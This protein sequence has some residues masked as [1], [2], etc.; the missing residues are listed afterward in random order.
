MFLGVV[1]FE[2]VDIFIYF[3]C[4]S[5]GYE[6]CFVLNFIFDYMFV[7]RFLEYVLKVV[8]IFKLCY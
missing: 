1:I 3:N 8:V 4:R 2:S 6:E 5:V 7:G